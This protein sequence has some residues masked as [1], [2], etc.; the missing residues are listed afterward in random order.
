V[1]RVELEWLYRARAAT[2]SVRRVRRAHPT[3]WR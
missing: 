2:F 3:A 1:S